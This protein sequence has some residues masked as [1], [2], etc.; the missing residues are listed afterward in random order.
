VCQCRQCAME[1]VRPEEASG[2]A[3]DVEAPPTSQS[4]AQGAAP[5]PSKKT[6]EKSK[7]PAPE[8]QKSGKRR[9]KGKGKDEDAGKASRDEN[10]GADAAETVQRVNLADTASSDDKDW[11]R[12]VPHIVLLSPHKT[13]EK[14]V[15]DQLKQTKRMEEDSRKADDADAK[16]AAGLFVERRKKVLDVLN[17]GLRPSDWDC[18]A[19]STADQRMAE[20]DRT[21]EQVETALAEYL[22]SAKDEKVADTLVSTEPS[23]DVVNMT[24]LVSLWFMKEARDVSKGSV[25]PKS[26]Y[27]RSQSKKGS[28]L[29]FARFASG[30]LR[31]AAGILAYATEI[32]SHVRTENAGGSDGRLK[33]C[34]EL[35][36]AICMAD[37]Q[38]IA[39]ATSIDRDHSPSLISSL[40]AASYWKLNEQLAQPATETSG[41]LSYAKWVEYAQYKATVAKAITYAYQG[42]SLLQQEDGGKARR[43]SQGACEFLSLAFDFAEKYHRAKPKT[44]ADAYDDQ[45][46]QE[47]KRLLY[48]I[49]RKTERENAIVHMRAVPVDLPPLI[50]KDKAKD[51]A[52]TL[53]AGGKFPPT[54]EFQVIQETSQ[55][56]EGGQSSQGS[57]CLR[58]TAACICMPLL[59]LI[60]VIGAIV[61]VL[62]LPC[63]LICCPCGALLQAAW[64][65]M[66]WM[67]KAPLHAIQW[68]AGGAPGEKSEEANKE[69]E[70][71][72]PV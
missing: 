41:P 27:F 69:K 49:D 51:I 34:A 35:L 70:Q 37:V 17:E 25:G 15:K 9:G 48:Q 16:E 58:W 68:A 52:K 39:V 1:A 40:S 66:E 21:Q 45:Y 38:S 23:V 53:P 59:A 42:L 65:I 46:H 8:K 5:Q 63:K 31:K 22:E 30:L 3:G 55:G 12:K 71:V 28:V 24:V 33:E 36:H 19:V 60:S 2:G 72:P 56:S 11:K 29:P 62:L 4:A 43:C 64:N 13:L 57:S 14:E 32:C 47:L 6:E 67:L 50:Q 7:P 54:E 44:S 20:L 10:P 18:P 26:E 61:W